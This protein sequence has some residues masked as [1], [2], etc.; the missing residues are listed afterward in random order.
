MEGIKAVGAKRRRDEEGRMGKRKEGTRREI[1]EQSDRGQIQQEGR[2]EGRKERE[3]G[4]REKRKTERRCDGGQAK[5][6]L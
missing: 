5:V 3:Q 2:K 6:E 4:R 1:W